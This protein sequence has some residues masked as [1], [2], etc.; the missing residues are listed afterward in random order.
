MIDELINKQVGML[1]VMQRTKSNKENRSQYLCL[2]KCEKVV[3][4]T[5]KQLRKGCVSCGCH[6]FKPRKVVEGRVKSNRCEIERA[7]R[8]VRSDLIR[9][10]YGDLKSNPK[11]G[12]IITQLS[13]KLLRLQKYV[14]SNDSIC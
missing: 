1:T 14:D 7:S 9:C 5:G 11:V 10:F 8:L 4:R 2:C 13:R 6:K 3:V 12:I